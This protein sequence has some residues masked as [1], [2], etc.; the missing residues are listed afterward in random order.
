[1][2][3]AAFGSSFGQWKPDRKVLAFGADGKP[4]AAVLGS[5][6]VT[7]NAINY[8]TNYS[9]QSNVDFSLGTIQG[10]ATR[11]IAFAGSTK[12]LEEAL[13]AERLLFQQADRFQAETARYYEGY[14][15]ETSSIEIPDKDLQQAYDWSRLSLVKGLVDNP[16]LGTG[17]VAGYGPSKG[18]YRPGF[19]WF[20]GRDSFWSSFALNSAGDWSSS[21]K[22]IEFISRFQRDDGKIPHEISQSAAQVAWSEDYPYEYASADATPLFIIAVRDYVQHSGDLT[23]ANAMWE[24]VQKAMAFSRSTVDS[25]G[26]AKNYGVGHGWVEGGPLLPVRVEFYMAGCYVEALRSF[27]ELAKWTRHTEIVG[28]YEKRA[29]E[30]QRKLDQLFWLQKPGRYAFALGNDGEPVDQPTVLSLVPEWWRL[31]PLERVQQMVV[32]LEDESHA[33]DWGMRIISSR[34]P[35][36][37]PAGYHF[38]S[39]WPLFTGWASLGEYHAHESAAGFA[40]L[41]ANSWL[42]LDGAG[43]N[44]TEVLSGET[45][46]PLSTA[47]PHQIWSA[48]M[49]ISPLLRGLFGLEV[50]SIARRV[51]LSP[52]LPP[53]W[54]DASVA[55]VGVT[56]GHLNFQ[57]HRSMSGL[58]LKIENQGAGN[59]TILFAPAYSPYTTVTAATLNDRPVKFSRENGNLDWHPVIEATISEGVTTIAIRH[60]RWFGVALPADPPQLAETSSNL[61]LLDE[62]WENENKRLILT[63]SGR[64]RHTYQFTIAGP[65][66]ITRLQGAEQHGGRIEL[67]M[68]SGSGYVQS[69]V[70]VT[71]R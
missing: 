44:T 17:L 67:T 8:A 69:Q 65:D 38:G 31:L 13:S 56:G 55:R 42:T 53:D 34:S 70:V 57:I 20:F 24:R 15:A 64:A 2:W 30:Q 46:S 12:S 54:T 14:L 71:L 29:T 63:F 47:T 23:F 41:K 51:T 27:V 40:N 19:A 52:H 66:N 60:T 22:A 37:N 16:F 39:V 21:R 18:S 62:K 59:L 58:T 3:P 43:G 35:L 68:P 49:V 25:E 32:E 61:K 45:Y 33:S 50:D 36:Y 4:Y 10:A 7:I 26:F 11:T 9:A 1:M 5:P 6:D 28:E 48:A